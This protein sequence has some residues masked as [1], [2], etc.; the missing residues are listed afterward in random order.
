MIACDDPSGDRRPA[1]IPQLNT[2]H[3]SKESHSHNSIHCHTTYTLLVFTASILT[4]NKFWKQ[5]NLL[6]KTYYALCNTV[7]KEGSPVDSCA[8]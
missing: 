4:T 2:Q 8:L 6:R 1:Q 7:S 3:A 5:H